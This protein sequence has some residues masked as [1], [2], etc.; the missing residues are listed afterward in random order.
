[1]NVSL[2]NAT[3]L[4]DGTA[5]RLF[6]VNQRANVSRLHSGRDLLRSTSNSFSFSRRIGPLAA[7]RLDKGAK[8][9]PHLASPSTFAS[10]RARS[11]VPF[12]PQYLARNS[13]LSDA[14]ST[15]AGHS[16]LQARHSRHRSR[17][18]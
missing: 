8:R 12:S 1:M 15:L 6:L 5:S 2:N 9:L 14:I 16:V 13:L 11:G 10:A 17:A 18:W 3:P 7:I 4:A